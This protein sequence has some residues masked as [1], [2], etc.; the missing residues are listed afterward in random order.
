MNDI[1]M[2]ERRN[3]LGERESSFYRHYILENSLK[4]PSPSINLI[5]RTLVYFQDWTNALKFR[6]IKK[7]VC[8]I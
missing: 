1:N 7:H 8:T 5:D 4:A 6:S 3:V 2:N